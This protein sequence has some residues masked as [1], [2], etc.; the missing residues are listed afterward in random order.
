MPIPLVANEALHDAMTRFDLD[1]RHT[2]D[3]AN[4]EQ[5]KAHRY[6]I[7]HEGRHYPVKQIISLAT[8][9]SVSEFSGGEAP[10]DAN[11]YIPVRHCVNSGSR[12]G[13]S[14]RISTFIA[15]LPR[16]KRRPL[17]K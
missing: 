3:W 2:P 15:F 13:V 14:C 12:F 10:G 11:Q 17:P 16:P 1:L 8:G 5:N 6:A 4:W 7:D 9:M